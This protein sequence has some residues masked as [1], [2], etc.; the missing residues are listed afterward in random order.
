MDTYAFHY[1]AVVL[2]L[3]VGLA[4]VLVGLELYRLG[5]SGPDRRHGGRHL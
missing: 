2:S 4:L 5:H 3:T 1:S